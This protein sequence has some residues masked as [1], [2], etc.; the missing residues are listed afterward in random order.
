MP[1]TEPYILPHIHR[2]VVIVINAM[3]D[4]RTCM[5]IDGYYSR[6]VKLRNGNGFT[7]GYCV[8]GEEQRSTTK[9]VEYLR[10]CELNRYVEG[11]ERS[12]LSQPH[13]RKHECLRSRTTL[14][15]CPGQGPCG[16]SSY[17]WRH[18]RR[19]A[20]HPRAYDPLVWLFPSVYAPSPVQSDL[21][22][23]SCT[24]I[25]TM[26]CTCVKRNFFPFSP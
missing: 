3:T 16:A 17:L 18:G 14:L 8:N 13:S 10:S 22:R 2:A 21:S 15:R 6:A 25:I 19:R 7:F 11:R 12:R 20:Q 9:V 24:W 1:V 23:L 4:E 5:C 26:L